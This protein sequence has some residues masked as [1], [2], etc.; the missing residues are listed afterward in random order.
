MLLL[1]E[2]L[3]VLFSLQLFMNFQLIE[4][5][6]SPLIESFT[7]DVE[8]KFIG[9]KIWIS[10]WK[11]PAIRS[12]DTTFEFVGKKL[13]QYITWKWTHNFFLMTCRL[14]LTL[15]YESIPIVDEISVFYEWLNLD[16]HFK[17]ASCD[18]RKINLIVWLINA[19]RSESIY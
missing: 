17:L 6:S 8:I 3:W 12:N 16:F 2:K 4:I 13:L 14:F 18:L 1:F 7:K 5:S 9:L 15:F 11:M 10:I 19:V